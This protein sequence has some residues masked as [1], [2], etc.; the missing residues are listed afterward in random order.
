MRVIC[1]RSRDHRVL[2][3]HVDIVRSVDADARRIASGSYDATIKIWDG[4]RLLHTLAGH[5]SRVY[6]VHVGATGVVSASVDGTVAF[7]DFA[8]NV[9]MARALIGE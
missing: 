5:G 4:K 7:W 2:R 8:Y 9:P 3:G 6:C 1:T